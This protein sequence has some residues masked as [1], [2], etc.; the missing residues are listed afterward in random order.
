MR[1]VCADSHMVW[2][3]V[4]VATRTWLHEWIRSEDLV[5]LA[6][7]KKALAKPDSF[8]RLV[9]LAEADEASLDSPPYRSAE[10]TSVAAG[11]SLDLTGFL[12]CSHPDC[13]THQ[14]DG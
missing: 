9:E 5:D 12:G 4:R 14:V 10:S 1:T 8:D 7:V 2:K 11:R 6:S 3:A 13:R